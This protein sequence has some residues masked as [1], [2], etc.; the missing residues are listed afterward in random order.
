[1]QHI[2]IFGWENAVSTQ[3]DELSRQ[4]MEENTMQPHAKTERGVQD[5]PAKIFAAIIG[6]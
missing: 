6:R 4:R 1:M 2:F 3:C 5:M